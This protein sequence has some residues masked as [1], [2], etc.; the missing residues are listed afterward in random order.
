MAEGVRTWRYAGRVL[1]EADHLRIIG[2]VVLG[3]RHGSDVELSALHALRGGR[4]RDDYRHMPD[5]LA[6]VSI[7]FMPTAGASGDVR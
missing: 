3:E 7:T 2:A 4:A 5:G 6:L 1:W